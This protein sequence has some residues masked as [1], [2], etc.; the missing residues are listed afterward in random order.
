[1]TKISAPS[2]PGRYVGDIF[3]GDPADSVRGTHRWDGR[4]WLPM[5]ARTPNETATQAVE[6][7][8]AEWLRGDGAPRWGD[9]VDWSTARLIARRLD[10]GVTRPPAMQISSQEPPAIALLREAAARFREYERHY[11]AKVQPADRG[12]PGPAADKINAV[13]QA[14]AAHNA[15]LAGRIEALLAYRSSCLAGPP[16]SDPRPQ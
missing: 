10:E 13:A 1:M 3:F 16:A 9:G 8:Q 12:V 4:A 7:W 5:A 15:E 11:L 6:R 2:E 14:N